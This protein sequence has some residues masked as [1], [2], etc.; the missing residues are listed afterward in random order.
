M[1]GNT[2]YHCGGSLYERGG[3]LV[4]A[5]CGS[6]VPENITSEEATLLMVAFQR[7]RHADFADAE[8]DFEDIIRRHPQNAQGYWGHLLARYGIKYEQDYDGRMIPTCYAASIER[9]QNAEDYKNA[10]RYADEENRAVF[11]EHA[12]YIE[13]VRREWVERASKEKPYDIFI[14]YKDSDRERGIDRTQ[15]SYDMQD[16][17]LQ[18]TKMGYRVFFSHESLRGKTGEKYEPYIYGALETAKVMIL[19]GSKPEYI[20]ATWVKNEWTR[21]MKRMKAGEK[22]QGSLIVACKG[23]SP[24][25]LPTA[26]ASLQCLD[27]G[28]MRFYT[29][30]FAAIEKTVRNTKPSKTDV[31]TSQGELCDHRQTEVIPGKKATC[32]E[33]GRTDMTVCAEC[34]E[35]LKKAVPIPATGHRFGEWRV[36]QKAGCTEDGWHERVCR[37]CGATETKPIPARGQHVISEEWETVTEPAPGKE[38]LKAKKCLVCGKH[39][40][41]MKIP[42]LPDLKPSEGLKYEITQKSLFKKTCRVVGMGTCKDT[43]V[44]IPA[45]IDGYRVTAIGNFAFDGCKSLSK[46]TIPNTVTSIGE[47]AFCGCVN[48]ETLN[49]PSSV[50]SI[51]WVAF[52]GCKSLTSVNIPNSVTSIGDG[53]FS[54]CTSLTSVN[55]PS[56]VTRIE[57]STFRG[58]VNLESLNIPRS[59]TSIGDDAFYFCESLTSVRYSGTKA[60]WREI[61]HVLYWRVDSVMTVECTDGTITFYEPRQQ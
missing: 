24:S 21:Y 6:I 7:L 33:N 20:G 18:L 4:C 37:S 47:S 53:A 58:C 5:Y 12:E 25:A 17:Y 48:L 57:E 38:G 23:F 10:L 2:C 42:A 35:T 13:R 46:V 31:P 40:E 15:D 55:I 50:T 14:S 36:A 51:G 8:Q 60:Q 34:G 44:I 61:G 39:I 1:N 9:V 28:Q 45:K 56:F 29:D 19:Y 41:E 52:C 27:A 11:K 59:V 3:R 32:T 30:L 43:H 16:L 22:K 49:I 54:D 26:L